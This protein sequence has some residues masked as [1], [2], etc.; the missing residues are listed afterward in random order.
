MARIEP[1][2][3]PRHQSLWSDLLVI[4]LFGSILLG[5][6]HVEQEWRAPL[7]TS[8]PIDL[9]P[10]V[11]PLYALYSLARSWIAY[12]LSLVFTILVASWAYYDPRARRIILPALDVLQSIPVLGFLP[13]LV[14]ALVRIFPNSNTGL[15]LACVIM[16]LTGQVWNMAF[17]YYDSLQGVPAEHRN[18]ARL[19]DFSPWQRFWRV[20]LPFGAQSLVYNSMVSMAGGWFFLS[21]TEA[22]RLGDQDFRLP[23]IGSYMSEAVARGNVPAQLYGVVAMAVVIITVDRLVWWPLVRWARRFNL[24]DF[25]GASSDTGGTGRLSL[26]LERSAAWR[27]ITLT[28][29]KITDALLRRRHAPHSRSATKPQSRR[30]FRTWLGHAALGGLILVAGYALV[31]LGLLIIRLDAGDWH[32][33]ALAT[34]CTSLRVFTALA[35][36][37]LWTVPAGVWLGLHPSLSNRLQPLIQFAASFPAPMVYPWILALVIAVGGTLSWG[38]IPL[39]MLGTQWYILFNVASAASAIPNDIRSCAALLNLSG[40]RRWTRYLLPAIAP[41]LV[42]GCITAAGG[43]W[44]ATIVSEY[45]HSGTEIVRTTGLGAYISHA[46]DAGDYPQLAAGVI[47]MAV[48]VVVVNRFVWKKL[49]TLANERC[50]FG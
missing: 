12:A 7:R 21:I 11:L 46:T 13:G 43:A 42:T 26:W 36:S 33:I 47:V 5:A 3:T 20:E 18:L 35:L 29:A 14:L 10:S 31:R 15:E 6:L 8:A 25:A 30:P 34:G 4:A 19:Y 2:P 28:G 1:N 27:R 9:S 40:M 32:D 16:I 44:N 45:I 50:R 41:G 48:I 23:G 24:D 49:Q 22:F 37:V 17:S 39:I 38:A